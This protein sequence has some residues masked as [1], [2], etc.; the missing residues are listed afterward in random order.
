MKIVVGRIAFYVVLAG[1]ST[2]AL[3]ALVIDPTTPTVL[4][5]GTDGGVYKSTDGGLRW[6]PR[7]N[8]L[9]FYPN[10]NLIY[11]SQLA[12]DPTAPTTLYVTAG[13][14]LFKSANGGDSWSALNRGW[15]QGSQGFGV[16]TLVISPRTP[17]TLYAAIN[18]KGVFKSTDRGL[19]WT[20][21]NN[22][23]PIYHESHV[24]ASNVYVTSLVIDPL[25]PT[26]LYA[27]VISNSGNGG[28]GIFKSTDGGARW[29]F[30]NL[31]SSRSAARK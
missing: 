4:Y 24:N 26:T 2:R 21:S 22:G 8:G 19:S 13:L 29:T 17:S 9:P 23:L 25:T 14:S 18:M 15:P 16:N 31:G 12:I 7:N 1:I 30:C 10:S 5:A 20:A 3:R 6:T 11:A 27:T 28:D